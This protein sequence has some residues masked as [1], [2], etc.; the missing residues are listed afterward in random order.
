M[1]SAAEPHSDRKLL[2]PLMEKRRRDRMN[3]SL[4]RLRLL[5]LAAT[6]DERLQNPKVEKAEILQKTVQFLRAQP[7]SEP[8]G[9]EELFLRRY[10]SGYRECLARAAHFLQAVPAEPPCPGLGPTAVC[11]P[12]LAAGPADAAGPPGRHGLPVPQAGPGCPGYHGYGPG[13]H[14]FGPTPGPSL[15]P[16]HRPDCGRGYHPGDGPGCPG[17]S[18][19]CP[20]DG[21]CCPDDGPGCPGDRSRCPGYHGYGPGLGPGL[22]PTFGPSWGPSLGPQHGPGR[23][24]GRCPSGHEDSRRRCAKEEAPGEGGGLPGPPRRVWRPWP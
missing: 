7:L 16:T 8:S 19:G 14:N 11:P 12:P 23:G 3:R 18:P 5:L 24:P 9:T 15:G 20:G 10:R 4:D 13:Y 17:D 22:G 1:S 2:K 6:R 21:P